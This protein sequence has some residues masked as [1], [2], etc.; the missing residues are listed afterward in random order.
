M[1]LY[2]LDASMLIR[3]KNEYYE[4]GR[5]D[6]YWDWL[7]HHAQNNRVKIPLEIFEEITVGK[8]ELSDWAKKNKEILLFLEEVDISLVQR[9]IQDGY[10]P[11]LNDIEIESLGRDPFLIAYAL[12]DK[13]NRCL[14]TMEGRSQRKRQN[15]TIPSVCDDLGIRSINAFE[16]G[17]ELDFRTNWKTQNP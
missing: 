10:A 2:F 9:V 16:F 17:R 15:R 8:D 5:V 1:L 12:K 14:V 7:S 11:D 6:E 4:F 13:S 3:A